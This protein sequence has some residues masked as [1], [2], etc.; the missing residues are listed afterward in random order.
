METKE[1]DLLYVTEGA[2]ENEK[3]YKA[4]TNNKS[5]LLPCDYGILNFF[6]MLLGF[7]LIG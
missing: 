5:G 6:F 3:Y 1:G 7:E 2:I 4:K